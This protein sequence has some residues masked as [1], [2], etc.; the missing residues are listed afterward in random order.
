ME[1]ELAAGP[2]KSPNYNFVATVG[3]TVLQ[4]TTITPDD[5]YGEEKTISLPFTTLALQKGKTLSLEKQGSGQAYFT[6][7]LSYF[8]P[9]Q[10]GGTFDFTAMPK[11]LKIRRE[12]FRLVPKAMESDGTLHFKTEPI[13]DHQA[14]AGETV[15]MKVFIET[16]I[17]LPYVIVDA[18]LPSG[19]EVVENNPKESLT[20]NEEEEKAILAGDWSPPWWTHQDILDDRLVFFASHI[21]AGKSE[22]HTFVRLEFPGTFQMPPVKLEGMYTNHIKAYSPLDQVQVVE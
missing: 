14:R 11:D 21:P 12:F 15:L 18:A 8:L 20:E 6:T 5:L 19:G 16:P 9:L 22:V 3:D 10:P 7:L 2:P 17:A 1:H 4:Q 13:I